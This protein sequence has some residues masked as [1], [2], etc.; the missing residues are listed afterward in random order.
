MGV[1]KALEQTYGSEFSDVNQ[2]FIAAKKSFSKA[3]YDEVM[4]YF[5]MDVD[6]EDPLRNWKDLEVAEACLPESVLRDISLHIYRSYATHGSPAEL[7]NEAAT[8]AFLLGPFQC[9]TCLFGGI[10]RDKPE[11][12]IPGTTLSGGGRVEVEIF[13]RETVCTLLRELKF[14]VHKDFAHNVGQA[15]CELFATW[16]LNQRNNKDAA[17]K[18]PA[19][20]IPVYVTL[21]DTNSSYC[22]SYDGK[23]F[24]RKALPAIP[25]TTSAQDYVWASLQVAQY[26]FAVLLDGYNKTLK[27]YQARSEHRGRNGDSSAR[28][29]HLP[30]TQIPVPPLMTASV[31]RTSSTG[32]AD[33]AKLGWQ[34]AQHFKR[35]HESKSE[36]AAQQGLD[37]LYQ[38][39]SAW[40]PA[41][42]SFKSFLPNAIEISINNIMAKYR[43]TRLYDPNPDWTPPEETENAIGFPLEVTCSVFY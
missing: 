38:S 1:F 43:N 13:C 23:E 14:D 42:S 24:R 19:L 2:A 18:E 8:A 27:L 4:R 34:S 15:C 5:S 29:S 10:L 37:L 17:V 20:F 25:P 16:Q 32:W 12:F 35:A 39:I 21:S 31:E 22:L 7:K 11:Q 30:V 41:S 3:N 36:I 40:P 6:A 33:A 28:G 26:L 9:L